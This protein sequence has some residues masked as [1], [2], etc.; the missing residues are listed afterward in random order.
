MFW[1][2]LSTLIMSMTGEGDDTYA[3]RA[4][5]E[6]AHDA[7]ENQVQ[8]EAHKRAALDTLNRAT[9]AFERHRQRVNKIS[10]CIEQADRRYSAVAADYERCL[11]DVEPAWNAAGEELI[12]LG[13]DLNRAL[14]PAELQAVR[15]RVERH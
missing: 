13:R 15:K 9:T 3:I 10:Q 6:R 2:A 12:V 1:I 11:V 4:F 8:D 14:T 5:F 7:V